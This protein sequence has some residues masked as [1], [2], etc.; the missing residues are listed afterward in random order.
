MTNQRQ[1]VLDYEK[2]MGRLSVANK[3]DVEARIFWA[4]SVAQAASPTDKT[5]A[6]NLQAA[7]MLEPMYKQMPKHPGIAH[8]IIHA[9]DVPPLAPKALPAARAAMPASRRSSRTRST[10][11]RTR[12]RASATGRNRSRPTSSPRTIAEKTNGIGEAMHARDYMTYAY[13]QMGM[14]S[15]AKENLE[16]VDAARQRGRRHA[17]RGGRRAEHV[18]AGGDSRALCDGAAAVDRGG[19]V[20]AAAG[21]EHAL[22]RSDH[23]LRSRRRRRSRRDGPSMPPP[24]SRSSRRSAI[25]RS[26]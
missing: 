1:R 7:E 18:R 9:Y 11:R 26:K 5:Y 17:G 16:H 12:S 19:G 2:A 15:Q 10:C 22:H 6:R 8:Y 23:A 4:L 3:A 24:T 21:A 14:D 13:L 20:A 25:A